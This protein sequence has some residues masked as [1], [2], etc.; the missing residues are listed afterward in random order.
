MLTIRIARD[1]GRAFVLPFSVAAPAL[2]DG[3]AS[4]ELRGGRI[5]ASDLNSFPD[6]RRLTLMDGSRVAARVEVRPSS[7]V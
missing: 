2:T 4:R 3:T 5:Q 6:A 7:R 1:T